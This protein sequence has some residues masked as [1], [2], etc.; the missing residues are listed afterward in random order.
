MVDLSNTN[1][2]LSIVERAF[3]KNQMENTMNIKTELKKID[4]FKPFKMELE[5]ATLAEVQAFYAIFN[6]PAITHKSPIEFDANVI[7]E[8]IRNVVGDPDGDFHKEYM[9]LRQSLQKYFT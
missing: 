2:T 3:M 1:A 9:R 5:F 8:E 4:K 7:R 6:T